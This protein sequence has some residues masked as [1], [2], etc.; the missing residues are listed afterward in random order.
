M[1]SP[2]FHEKD[3]NKFKEQNNAVINSFA[4]NK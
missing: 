1:L 2:Y 4:K 3:K